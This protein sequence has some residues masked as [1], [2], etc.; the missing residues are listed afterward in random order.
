MKIWILGQFFEKIDI[1]SKTVWL[2]FES[3]NPIFD[4]YNYDYLPHTIFR[5]YL[6]EFQLNTDFATQFCILYR[7]LLVLLTDRF[8]NMLKK[9]F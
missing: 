9:C 5:F 6:I 8:L 3:K 4:T 1:L 7:K 2:K